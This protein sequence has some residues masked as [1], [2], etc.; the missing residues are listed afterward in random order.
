MVTILI[1]T[2]IILFLTW[3]TVIRDYTFK[4]IGGSW[5]FVSRISVPTPS[6]VTINT[7]EEER[8]TVRCASLG[9]QVHSYEFQI[10]PF[11]NMAFA[12]VYGTTQPSQTIAG[13]KGGKIYYVRARTIKLNPSGRRVHGRWS[14]VRSARVKEKKE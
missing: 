2:G 13:L 7:S 6:S 12:K 3:A 5:M 1:I 10:S 9:S 14:T 8:L 4:Q 11:R